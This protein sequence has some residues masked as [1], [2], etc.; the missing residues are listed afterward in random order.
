MDDLEL[1]LF[2]SFLVILIQT[3]IESRPTS[4]VEDLLLTEQSFGGRVELDSHDV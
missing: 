3:F 4:A 2:G 1:V